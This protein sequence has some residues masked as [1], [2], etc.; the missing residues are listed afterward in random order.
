MIM[1]TEKTEATQCSNWL[2][3][4]LHRLWPEKLK[5]KKKKKK[6]KKEQCW[7]RKDELNN[8]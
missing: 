2:Q 6:K 1:Y 4:S 5:K 3:C 8:M 7:T